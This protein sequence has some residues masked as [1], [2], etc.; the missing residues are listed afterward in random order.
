[1]RECNNIIAQSIQKTPAKNTTNKKAVFFLLA[2]TIAM[3]MT[4][5]WRY[6]RLHNIAWAMIFENKGAFTSLLGPLT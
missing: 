2:A 5:S 6:Y 1:M 3:I 4:V